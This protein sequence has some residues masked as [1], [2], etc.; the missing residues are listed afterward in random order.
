MRAAFI[1]RPGAAAD[2][3]FGV[4]PDPAPGPTD[5]LVDVIA[6]TVNH[7]DTFVRSGRFRTLLPWPFVVGRD[8]VGRVARAGPG[9][10]GFAEGELVWCNSLGHGG[11]QGSA[12]ERAVVPADRLY[13]LPDGVDPET[14][15]T[16]AHP[17]ATA[18][19]ALFTHGRLRAGETVLVEGAAGNV[20]AALVVLAAAA[21]AK[22]VATSAAADADFVKRLGAA[23]VLDY[24]D[25]GLSGRVREA[26]PAGADLHVDTSGRNELEWVLPLL[27][28]RGR[29]VVLAGAARRP[30]LPAGELYMSDCSVVGFAISHAT[31]AELAEA[32]ALINRLTVDGRLFPRAVV[33]LRLDQAAEAHRLIEAGE[34]HGRRAVLTP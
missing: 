29:T 30:V 10:T 9:S 4:I 11:R 12:A 6:T 20:G 33:P 17:A 7:V 14:A 25:P 15:V 18:Y 23:Q 34:L 2:I 22:V 1:E 28:R 32:A 3:R 27:A 5:V 21:G 13:R 19:L 8:L 24:R 26:C 31:A 16:V